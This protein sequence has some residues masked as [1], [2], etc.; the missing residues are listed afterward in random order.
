MRPS[1]QTVFL[2][3]ALP[4]A[5]KGGHCDMVILLLESYPPGFGASSALALVLAEA[6]FSA[7]S[8]GNMDIVV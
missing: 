7:L 4:R 1:Q 6:L 3:A 8:S 2:D 5:I